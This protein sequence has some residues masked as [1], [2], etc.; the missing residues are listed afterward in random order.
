MANQ[1]ITVELSDRIVEKLKKLN[2]HIVKR[3]SS[4]EEHY[5]LYNRDNHKYNK[6]AIIIYYEDTDRTKEMM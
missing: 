2:I 4:P 1:I 5:D 3:P 6:N